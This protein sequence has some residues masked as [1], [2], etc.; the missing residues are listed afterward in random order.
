MVPTT[1]SCFDEVRVAIVR[2]HT[3]LRARLRGLDAATASAG[4]PLASA[5]LRVGLLRLAV[6]FD[7]H[8]TFEEQTLGPRLRELDAWGPGR[9]AAMLAEHAEQRMRVQHVC[10]AVEDDQ[11]GLDLS[12]E[13]SWL[14]V[15]FLEDMARE[16]RELLELAQL[17]VAGAL[18]QMAG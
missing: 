3:E 10:A 4:S 8:L 14:V 9:E 11:S 17:D 13:I 16:E 12:R 5:Y 2:Q 6:Q 7:A 18:D 1:K 15:S